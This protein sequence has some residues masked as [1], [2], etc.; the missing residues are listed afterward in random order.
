MSE[1][2]EIGPAWAMLAVPLLFALAAAGAGVDGVL[3]RRA[4]GVPAWAGLSAPFD[5]TARLLRQRRRRTVSADLLLWRIGG[6]ALVIVALLKVAVIPLGPWTLSDMPIGVVWFNTMDVL[7]WA[8]VWLVGWGANSAYSL[9]G[10]YRFLA[11]ALSYELPLMFALTAPIVAAS[12]LR[13]GDI[14]LAQQGLWFVVWMPVAFLVFCLS[15]IAFSVWGPFS[16]AAGADISGGVLSELSGVDRLLVLVGRYALLTAG[17]GFAATL[18]LGGGAGPV[19]PAWVWTLAK[20]VLLLAV[21]I[22]VRRHLPAIRPDRFAEVG[23]LVLLPVTL[24]Q[25]LAV[26][27]VVALGG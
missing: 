10:G 21:F 15:V 13:V 7:I 22:G 9:L 25:V 5:E 6:G 8:L 14:V 23:L 1:I 17:A 26:S 12:S 19:L 11:Q 16:A 27:I 18:F 3:T 4:A 24:L 2:V 20:T